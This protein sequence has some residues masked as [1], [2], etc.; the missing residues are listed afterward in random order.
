MSDY[1]MTSDIIGTNIA[2]IDRYIDELRWNGNTEDPHPSD[3]SLDQ[4]IT[5]KI[6]IPQLVIT[7]ALAIH[8]AGI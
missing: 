4:S 8:S 7:S 6:R 2:S 1:K 5:R 3:R